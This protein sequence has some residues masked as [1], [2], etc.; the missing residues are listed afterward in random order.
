VLWVLVLSAVVVLFSVCCGFVVFRAVVFGSCSVVLSVS[1]LGSGVFFSPFWCL[2]AVVLVCFSCVVWA[3]FGAG[4]VRAR[5][6]FS[7]PCEAVAA[8]FLFK[9]Q[10]GMLRKGVCKF[11]VAIRSAGHGVF[12]CLVLVFVWHLLGDIFVC[13][14]LLCWGRLVPVGKHAD[15]GPHYELCATLHA[16]LSPSL[17]LIRFLF[18]SLSVIFSSSIFFIRFL[19]SM[20]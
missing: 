18:L 19:A 4:C 14:F 1:C 16:S 17:C 2:F 6:V 9:E 5:V 15:P 11:R 3:V 7:G 20:T 12:V 13:I 8:G 10:E